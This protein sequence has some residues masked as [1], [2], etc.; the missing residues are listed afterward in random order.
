M[1]TADDAN[2]CLVLRRVG[3]TAACCSK[4]A[5]C[6]HTDLQS[7]KEMARTR[8]VMPNRED[9]IPASRPSCEELSIADRR[10]AE[11]VR[12]TEYLA[13]PNRPYY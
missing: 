4:I 6:N 2:P 8:S 1:S 7:D 10:E 3:H 12:E 9:V 13:H 5:I 11:P